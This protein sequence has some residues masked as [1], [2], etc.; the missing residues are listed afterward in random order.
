MKPGDLKQISDGSYVFQTTFGPST[1]KEENIELFFKRTYRPKYTE[2]FSY[3]KQIQDLV[4]REWE[5][6]EIDWEVI[7][8]EDADA[9]YRFLSGIESKIRKNPELEQWR[10]PVIN[11]DPEGGI[12]CYW[13]FGEDKKEKELNLYISSKEEWYITLCN[14]NKRLVTG[15]GDTTVE[16]F[17][18]LW[19][20][21]HNEGDVNEI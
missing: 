11:P 8:Q 13:S 6:S 1:I 7:T 16:K 3:Y 17:S 12:T 15:S 20:W 14:E 4:G 2:H 5:D 19:S 18:K 10:S 21:L 9:T